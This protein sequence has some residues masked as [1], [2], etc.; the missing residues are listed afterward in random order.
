MGITQ[1]SAQQIE[2]NGSALAALLIDA[3][4]G[5]AS[6]SFLA[7]LAQEKAD[8]YWKQVGSDVAREGRIVLVAQVDGQIVGCVHLALATQPNASHRAEVQKLL[9]H[10]AYRRQ[11]LATQLMVAAEAA[12]QRLGR[13]LVVLDTEENSPAEELYAR[14]GYRRAGMIPEFARSSSGALHGTVFFISCSAQLE[15]GHGWM[16]LLRGDIQGD[17]LATEALELLWHYRHLR[18][19]TFIDKAVAWA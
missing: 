6:V 13:S 19:G 4:E 10:S 17:S 2:A 7:P 8:A 16:A 14:L 5:G 12:A 11:G 1:L 9:V 15:T 18:R 3:V